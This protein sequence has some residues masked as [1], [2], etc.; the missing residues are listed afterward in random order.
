MRDI[1]AVVHMT[2]ACHVQYV[3]QGAHQ[4]SELGAY[5]LKRPLVGLHNLQARMHSQ[6]A[7]TH[8]TSMTQVWL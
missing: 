2:P 8:A 4:R 1:C 3:V 6:I 5:G 7:L